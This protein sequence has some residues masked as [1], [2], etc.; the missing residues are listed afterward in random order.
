MSQLIKRAIF[1]EATPPVQEDAIWIQY[2]PEEK[3]YRFWRAVGIVWLELRLLGFTG[4]KGEQG[5]VGPAGPMCDVR[6]GTVAQLPIGS[7][8]TVSIEQDESGDFYWINFGI[9]E[10]DIS[11]ASY[12]R[13][14]NSLKTYIDGKFAEI[15]AALETW[16]NGVQDNLDDMQDEID[17]FKETV[18]GWMTENERVLANALVRHEEQLEG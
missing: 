12:T 3:Q 15:S 16:K 8:P 13:L 6:V 4:E 2:I 9:P 10:Y 17:N 7:A 5:D 1:S 18:E 14:E 11:A